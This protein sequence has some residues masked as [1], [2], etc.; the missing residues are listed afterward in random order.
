MKRPLARLAAAVTLL[1]ALSLAACPLP[2]PL[3]EVARTDGGVV[4]SLRF[5]LETVLPSDPI[6]PVAK[7]CPDGGVPQFNVSAALE[8]PDTVE[9]VEARWFVDYRVD[10]PDARRSD[11]IPGS[12]DPADPV[13]LVPPPASQPFVFAMPAFNPADPTTRVHVLELVVCSVGFTPLGNDPPGTLYPNR[14]PQ[15]GFEAAQIYR[16]IFEYVDQN[17]RCN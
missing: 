4:T 12:G 9:R 2:Q 17:G 16:W 3:P 8:D 11:D 14:T 15:L 7:T 10:A 13:R 5:R 6:V 1:L